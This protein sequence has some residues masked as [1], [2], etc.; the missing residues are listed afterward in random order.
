MSDNNDFGAFVLGFLAGGLAGAVVALLFAPQSGDETRRLIKEKAI[1]LQERASDT[2]EDALADAE[3][4][5]QEALRRAE[6][7]YNEAKARVEALANRSKIALDDTKEKLTAAK[8]KKVVKP[9]TK[10]A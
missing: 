1:D 3:R 5:T 10:P 8:P 4:A 2:M 6:L 9:A 7:V